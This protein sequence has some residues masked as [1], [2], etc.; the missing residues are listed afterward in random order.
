MLDVP[1]HSIF[2]GVPTESSADMNVVGWRAYKVL[3]S[4]YRQISIRMKRL[5]DIHPKDDYRSQEQKGGMNH[6]RIIGP[7]LLIGIDFIYE[8]FGRVGH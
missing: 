1:S 2:S 5:R 3:S 7:W 6:T 4:V 8:D